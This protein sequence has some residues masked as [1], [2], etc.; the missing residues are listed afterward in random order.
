MSLVLFG[1]TAAIGFLLVNVVDPYA[2]A[3]ASPTFNPTQ[4]FAGQDAQSFAVTAAVQKQDITRDGYSVTVPPPPPPPK[5]APAPAAAPAATAATPAKTTIAAPA[6]GPADP[7]SAQGYAQS[8]LASQG[9]GNDQFACLVALWNR[10]SGW[11]IHA[12]NR[13][14]GAYGIPQALPGSKMASAGADW[15]TSYVTQVK[16]GLGYVESRYGT[17]CGAWGHSQATGWY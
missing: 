17:P 2:G 16:W 7:G 11:N 8:L 15:A 14:S 6:V 9:L 12:Q 10:E 13:S 3:T 4:R 5:P 1:F